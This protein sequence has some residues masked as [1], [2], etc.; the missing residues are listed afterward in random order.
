[1]TETERPATNRP[2]PSSQAAVVAVAT[3]VPLAIWAVAVPVLGVDIQAADGERPGP[4]QTIGLAMILATSAVAA[5]A[6]WALVAVLRRITRHA[7]PIWNAVAVIILLVSMAGPFLSAATPAA[8]IVLALMHAGVAAVI[9]P[10]LRRTVC[11]PGRV[12]DA[13]TQATGP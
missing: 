8:A 7:Q 2:S 4:A 9:V 5:L 12:T 6:G 11:A 13:R 3:L 1:M 10:G